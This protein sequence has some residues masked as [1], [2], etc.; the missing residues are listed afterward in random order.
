MSEFISEFKAAVI[1]SYR[2]ELMMHGKLYRALVD[3]IQSAIDDYKLDG[4]TLAE[5][6]ADRIIGD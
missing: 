1:R 4:R 3:S 6:I 5:A 2:K